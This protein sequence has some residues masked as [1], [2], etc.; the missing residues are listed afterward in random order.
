MAARQVKRWAV[1]AKKIMEEKCTALY[2]RLNIVKDFILALTARFPL[3]WNFHREMKSRNL[4]HLRGRNTTLAVLW[5]FLGLMIFHK[6]FLSRLFLR[7]RKYQATAMI[8]C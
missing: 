2:V 8:L 5:R 6:Y 7:M 3:L 1:G 4:Y